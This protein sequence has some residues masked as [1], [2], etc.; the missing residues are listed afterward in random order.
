MAN[1][2]IQKI[3]HTLIIIVLGTLI[4]KEGAFLFVPLMWGAFFAFALNPISSWLE[5]RRIP[6]GVA[7]FLSICLVVV[8]FSGIIYLLVNQLTGLIED[9]PEITASIQNRLDEYI[10]SLNDQFGLGVDYDKVKTQISDSLNPKNMNVL[11]FQTGRTLTLMGIIPL[12]IFL[13]M[14]YKDFFKEFLHKLNASRDEEFSFSWSGDYGRLIQSYL[15]GL[16]KVTG[17]VAVLSGIYFYLIDIQYF[18]LFAL[19]IAIMNLIPYVGVIISSFFTVL[20]VFLTSDTFLYPILTLVVLWG[21]QLLENNIITPVVV[22]AEVKL[23]ALVVLLSILIGGWV[24]GVSGMILFIPILGIIK[25]TL[26]KSENH[27]PFAYLLSDNIPVRDGR[28]NLWKMF[29]SK[30]KK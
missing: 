26:E 7:V 14:Y 11:V 21:I 12:Y 19:F 1:L 23:N 28:K 3:A 5:D 2:S 8:F 25:I 30:F 22:G 20:Y 15:T 6:R 10:G 18:V 17:I 13:L 4:L 27:K 24:W 16:V 29:L 9:I